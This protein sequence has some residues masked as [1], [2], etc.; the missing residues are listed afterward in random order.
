M[1]KLRIAVLGAGTT[2]DARARQYLS[3]IARL[4]DHYELAAVCDCDP[5]VLR[6]VEDAFSI[7][8]CYADA[9]SLFDA[10]QPDV[11]LSLTPKDSHIVMALT[12][13]RQG[14][15]VITEI[16]A[17][18]TRRY[19]DA[20]AT[21]CAEHD[22]LW[23]VGEQVWLWPKEQL[24]QRIVQAGL[25]GKV[26]H[27]RLSYLTG[28]YHGFSGVR[29]LLEKDATRVLGY[30]GEVDT[31]PYVAYGGEPEST[32]QWESAVIEFAGGAVCL[33]E[34]PPRV[35]PSTR[36]AYPTGWQIE[37]PKGHLFGD[38]LTLYREDR[39]DAYDIV[40]RYIEIDGERVLEEVRVETDPP[41]VWKNP[42]VPYRIGSP[43][44]VSKASILVGFHDAITRGGSPRYGV[45]NGLKDYELCL[46][47]RESARR[48]NQ[49]VSLPLG[50]PTELEQQIEA[51]FVRRYGHDPIEETD[52]LL[53]T[54][55]SRS[56]TL[57]P[58][59]HWL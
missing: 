4:T 51:E 17:A 29:A 7:G 8:T 47:I 19:A 23:E 46:A 48:G 32:I 6:E 56:A 33:F 13:A 5:D 16:P 42:Y 58:F 22:V 57:W 53:D 20:I 55:F 41:V 15:H 30:V 36:H 31:E 52:A 24:K 38:R 18:L 49:W 3:T 37:G 9:R 45:G 11:V 39:S 44:D 12:A 10:E 35:F 59:A 25:L 43:D 54:A 50:E 40:E 34:K 28:Q 1:T 2:S 14:A 26:S 21:T 27:A